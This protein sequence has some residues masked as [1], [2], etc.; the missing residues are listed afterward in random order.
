VRIRLFLLLML[1]SVA[2]PR[3]PAQTARTVILDPSIPRPLL[4]DDPVKIVKLFDGVDV[5]TG[6]RA[7]P[8]FRG[9]NQ[10]VRT[11]ALPA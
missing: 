2:I 8:K 10:M 4:P 5:K 9:W 6:F 7:Y 3:V 11:A 1:I